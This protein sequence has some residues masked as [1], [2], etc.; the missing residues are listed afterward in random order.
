MV[1]VVRFKSGFY[2]RA[3]GKRKSSRLPLRQQFTQ[4]PQPPHPLIVSLF[5]F[6][7]QLPHAFHDFLVDVFAVGRY[8]SMNAGFRRQLD[9]ARVVMPACSAM[10]IGVSVSSATSRTASKNFCRGMNAIHPLCLG[11]PVVACCDCGFNRLGS[12][13][14]CVASYWPPLADNG[15]YS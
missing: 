7:E 8:H 12:S 1:R 9:S 3:R 10:E 2:K 6:C 4:P 15:T 13:F 14:F 5:A 11:V